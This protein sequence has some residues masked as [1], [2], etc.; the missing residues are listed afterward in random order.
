MQLQLGATRFSPF[1]ARGKVIS[2]T[3]LGSGTVRRRAAARRTSAC[4]DTRIH[5]NDGSGFEPGDT[6]FGLD[7][8]ACRRRYRDR[9]EEMRRRVRDLPR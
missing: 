4:L 1:R 9:L 7:H 5:A 8:A 2:V 3:V 6:P